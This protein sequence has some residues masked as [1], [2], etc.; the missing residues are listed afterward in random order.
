MHNRR[1]C[2]IHPSALCLGT[3]A[4]AGRPAPAP[5]PTTSTPKQTTATFCLR[6]FRV[7]YCPCALLLSSGSGAAVAPGPPKPAPPPQTSSPETRTERITA[8][9]LVPRPCTTAL[10]PDK[11]RE[12][13]KHKRWRGSPPG[14]TPFSVLKASV[15]LV[16]T[17]M[18]FPPALSS[19]MCACCAGHLITN[20]TL[21]TLRVPKLQL[22]MR[23][24]LLARSRVSSGLD[25]FKHQQQMALSTA[26]AA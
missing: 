1:A 11:W 4:G 17:S 8:L 2:A 10:A 19:H 18:H 13:S 16:T 21:K 20:R 22:C 25:R 15:L 3:V 9:T 5:N 14:V 7:P 23:K 6:S 26:T 24:H 12:G